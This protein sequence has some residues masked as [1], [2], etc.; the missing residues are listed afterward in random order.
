MPEGT[1]FF[2]GEPVVRITAPLIQANLLTAF[3]ITS[4]CSNTIF[5]S[6][7]IRSVIAAKGIAVIGPSSNRA[8][9]FESAFKAQRSGF[10][11]GGHDLPNPL[12]REK[13]GLNIIGGAT[14]AYHAYINSYSSE[15][16]AMTLAAKH[17][18]VTL[19]LMVDTYNYR[20]GIKNAISVAKKIK[21]QVKKKIKIVVDSGDLYKNTIF[22]R[23]ELDRA[24]LKDIKITVASNLDEFKISELLKKRIP[25]DTFIVNTE[26]VTSSDDPKMEAAYKISEIIKPNGKIISKMKMS[27]GKISLPGRKQVYRRRQG[28]YWQEDIIGLDKEKGLGQPLLKPVIKGGKSVYNLPTVPEIKS[29][30]AEQL[31]FLPKKYLEIK[32]NYKYP[33]K[34]SRK[35]KELIRRTKK[36]IIK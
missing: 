26:A 3:L 16:E 9:S 27:A 22:V 30:V 6:K 36:E 31:K 15:L 33:V 23:K 20:Q 12:I 24:G 34:I 2:P 7:Y 32:K 4:L 1:L 35:L 17:A 14:I 10:I 25:A 8:H 29:Y 13:L 19:S 11:A 18:K 5:S 28:K 21:T